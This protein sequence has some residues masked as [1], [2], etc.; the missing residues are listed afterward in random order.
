[1]ISTKELAEK[2]RR[3]KSSKEAPGFDAS[4]LSAKEKEKLSAPL[5]PAQ[6]YKIGVSPGLVDFGE[7]AVRSTSVKNLEFTNSLDQPILIEIEVNKSKNIFQ[8]FLDL[9]WNLF[10]E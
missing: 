5:S 7:I 9:F 6:I 1:M 10:L 8:N 3:L 4:S 2:E